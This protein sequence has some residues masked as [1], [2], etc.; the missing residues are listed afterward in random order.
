MSS[1]ASGNSH[2]RLLAALFH[3]ED[4][5]LSAKGPLVGLFTKYKSL[6]PQTLGEAMS[7]VFDAIRDGSIPDADIDVLEVAVN[8]ALDAA[9]YHFGTKGPPSA[10]MTVHSLGALKLYTALTDPDVSG[11]YYILA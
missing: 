10:E 5:S 9:E 6:P 2:T 1:F 8:L 4:E 11:L 7:T 3:G